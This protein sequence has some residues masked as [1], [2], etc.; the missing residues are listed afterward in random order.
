MIICDLINETSILLSFTCE[1]KKVVEF[2][3]QNNFY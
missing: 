1:K 3:P 2:E